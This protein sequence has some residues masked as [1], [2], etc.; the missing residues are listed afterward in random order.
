[1]EDFTGLGAFI[2]ARR[3]A[4]SPAQVGL[5]DTGPRRTPGLRR[6]EVA[7]LAGLS[8]G[9]YARLEQGREKYPSDQVLDA[10]TRVFGLDR[11]AE[12]HLHHLARRTG[13]HWAKRREDVSPHLQDMLEAYGDTP[14]MILSPRLDIL[15]GNRL[16][17]ALY[18]VVLEDGNLVRFTFLNPAARTFYQ[19]WDEIART[20]VAHLRAAASVDPDDTALQDLVRQLSEKS[21][22]FLRL[23]QQYDVR[24]KTR[25]IKMLHHHQVGDLT[26]IYQSFDVSGAPGQQLVTYQAEAGSPSE[27]QLARLSALTADDAT[28]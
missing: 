19:N 4:T 6:E 16:G 11:E 26:L 13:Q 2:R 9:Y 15:A 21:P 1:M 23:W 8:E 18:S 24:G 7:T 3:A 22:E 17:R 28:G 14:A 25:S 5:P 10:L 20:G 12:E 27:T